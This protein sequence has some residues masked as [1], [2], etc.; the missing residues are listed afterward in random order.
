MKQFGETTFS[1]SR[2]MVRCLVPILA[3]CA[4]SF[5]LLP[6]MMGNEVT[7]SQQIIM[8]GTSLFCLLC[9]PAVINAKRF[10]WAARSATLSVFLIYALYLVVTIRE[11][12]SQG[13]SFANHK[14]ALSGFVAIG[15]PCLLYSVVGRFKW[16]EPRMD[17]Y[18]ISSEGLD[19]LRRTKRWLFD[20]DGNLRDLDTVLFVVP[21][22]HFNQDGQYVGNYYDINGEYFGVGSEDLIGQ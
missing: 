8:M 19:E 22:E 16:S 7:V 6:F 5:M 1:G 13:G 10:W 14:E 15:I 3:I 4:L 9:I 21:P 12:F 17:Y 2:F 18:I 11:D 20:R